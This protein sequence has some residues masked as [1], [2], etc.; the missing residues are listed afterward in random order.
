MALR[1][2][3]A[4]SMLMCRLASAVKM[5]YPAAPS[6]ELDPDE[7]EFIP[8]EGMPTFEELGFT[9]HDLFDPVW[10]TKHGLPV[11]ETEDAAFFKPSSDSSLEKR[12]D[13]VCEKGRPGGTMGGLYACR[14]YLAALGQQ[15]Q[16]CS[17][18]YQQYT[19]YCNFN[20][21]GRVTK[22]YGT[23]LKRYSTASSCTDVSRA[24]QFALTCVNS[25]CLNN[26]ADNCG[27]GRSQAAAYGNGDLIVINESG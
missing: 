17:A 1:N 5:P 24:V 12:W 27:A 26:P 18:P 20:V 4:I 19:E 2:I 16:S 7:M 15:G 6:L 10:R 3:L 14:D 21:W 13:D 22:V 8:V 23:S 9:T 11:N 25:L